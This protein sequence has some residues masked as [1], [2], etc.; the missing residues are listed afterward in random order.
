[1]SDLTEGTIKNHLISIFCQLDVRDLT[2]AALW[3]HQYL[4]I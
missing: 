3:A 4:L 2:Q 1:M